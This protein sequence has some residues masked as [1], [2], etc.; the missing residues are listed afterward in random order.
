MSL[1]SKN[2]N[3]ANSLSQLKKLFPLDGAANAI[4]EKQKNEAVNLLKTAYKNE[5][6]GLSSISNILD[7]IY[8]IW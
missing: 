7:A 6:D 2:K 4:G 3:A 5:T 8:K 1:Y